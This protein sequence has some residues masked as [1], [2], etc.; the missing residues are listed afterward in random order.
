[1]DE[2][3]IENRDTSQVFSVLNLRIKRF[4]YRYLGFLIVFLIIIFKQ[5]F[6][7]YLLFQLLIDNEMFN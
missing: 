1:M 2:M 5:K 6:I 7:F 4:K 3:D